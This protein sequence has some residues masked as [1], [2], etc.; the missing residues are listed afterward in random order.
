MNQCSLD[1]AN[2]LLWVSPTSD[3]CLTNLSGGNNTDNYLY[4]DGGTGRMSGTRPRGDFAA[5]SNSA[6]IMVPATPNTD[7]NPDPPDPVTPPEPPKPIV[8]VTLNAIASGTYFTTQQVWDNYE[9][10]YPNRMRQGCL[11]WNGVQ[12]LCGVF[13][14]DTSSLAGKTV[15]DATLTLTRI[16]SGPASDVNV[17]VYTTEATSLKSANPT[18]TAANET[19]LGTIGNGATMT[20][21]LPTSFAQALVTNAGW[22]VMLNPGDTRLMNGRGYSQNYCRF[23]GYGETGVPVLSI[24]YQE[25]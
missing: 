1:N 8:T 20:Y 7:L 5:N 15:L 17:K 21:T 11:N 4:M 14:F 6:Y 23:A 18:S 3:V 24:T 19:T 16:T 9:P 25:T 2:R 10:S 13:W 12:P 22:G